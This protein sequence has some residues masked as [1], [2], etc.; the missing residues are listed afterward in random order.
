MSFWRYLHLCLDFLVMLK[1]GLI[2]KLWL[3]SK[4][5]M[6]HTRQE[7]ITMHILPNIARSK[8]NQTMKFG[9]LIKYNMNNIFLKKLY[10]KCGGKGSSRPFYKNS[11][12]RKS[13]SNSPWTSSLK[14]YKVY[15]MSK[16]P[17]TKIY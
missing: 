15:W 7:I 5:L 1:N 4:F 13:K 2:R 11:K 16:S 8:Y 3:I 9:Q 10:T 6:S 17:S 14:C 12:L